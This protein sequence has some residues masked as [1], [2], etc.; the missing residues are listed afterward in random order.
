[1]KASVFDT[2]IYPT[3]NKKKTQSVAKDI[4]RN[5][6]LCKYIQEN[7]VTCLTTLIRRR[8]VEDMVTFDGVRYDDPGVYRLAIKPVIESIREKISN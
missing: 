6:N 4:L 8:I 7:N 5:K 2:S 3:H 1:M